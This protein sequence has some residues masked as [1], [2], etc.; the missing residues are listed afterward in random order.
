M[1]AILLR[2]NILTYCGLIWPYGFVDL[3][4]HCLRQWLVAW[5]HQILPERCWLSISKVMCH[6]SKGI[7][8]SRSLIPIGKTR[9][10]IAFLKLHPYPLGNQWVECVND[11]NPISSDGRSIMFVHV[12]RHYTLQCNQSWSSIGKDVWF[13]HLTAINKAVNKEV[14]WLLY[15]LYQHWS[16]WNSTNYAMLL[17]VLFWY[18]SYQ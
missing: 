7:T 11:L 4:Q 1:V 18:E 13:M 17:D 5:R 2:Q 8:K 6:S 9:L 3:S 12:T 10:K 14:I 15:S 16:C